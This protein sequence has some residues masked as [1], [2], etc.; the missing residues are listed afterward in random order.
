MSFFKKAAEK[1]KDAQSEAVD[2]FNQLKISHS[3]NNDSCSSNGPPPIP[4]RPTH[5]RD[6]NTTGAKNNQGKFIIRN[7]NTGNLEVE[8]TGEVIKFASLCAPELFDN[9]GFEKEDTMRTIS[10]FGIWPVTRTYTLKVKSCRINRGHI[11]GWDCERND[12]MYDEDMFK[13]I[14]YTI[15]MAAKYNVRL[16]IPIINQDFGSEETNWVGN[17]SDLI[18]HRHGLKD[19]HEAQQMNWWEHPDCIDSMKKI[20]TFLLNRGYAIEMGVTETS[21]LFR[22]I[23]SLAPRTLIMDGSFARTDAIQYSYEKKVLESDLVDIISWHYYGYGEKRRVRD[24]VEAARNHKKAFICGEYGF[25]AHGHEFE[26]FLKHCSD[27]GVAGT[28]AW[29]LR[30]HSAKGGFKTHGEGNGIW[31]Y[32]APGWKPYQNGQ[33]DPEWD[34]REKDVIGAI[35]KAAFK[36]TGDKPPKIELD[37]PYVFLV[38]EGQSFSW[39]GTA[40]ADHYEVWCNT[41]GGAEDGWTL[42]QG[43]VTDNVKEGRLKY[44]SQVIY[45]QIG[46]QGAQISLRMRGMTSEKQPGPFSNVI[47]I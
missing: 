18:R 12:F 8:G 3:S 1:L 35:R 38:D 37:A 31:S 46:M 43:G 28:L 22:G 19:W 36:L 39:R 29:S 4:P 47:N 21:D 23:K 6:P 7:P 5:R 44:P 45:D 11:N 26:N 15:A 24:D 30:P 14:D 16:I 13:S 2:K 27:H 40:W 34:H 20:V 33:D 10:Q 42:C 41:S 32:H 9:E 17:F 25:F